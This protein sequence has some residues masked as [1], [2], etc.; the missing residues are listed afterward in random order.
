VR[1]I[2]FITEYNPFRF[3][4]GAQQRTYLLFHALQTVGHVHLFCMTEE[5]PP[6][7]RHADGYTV[8][9]WGQDPRAT[10]NASFRSRVLALFKPFI[11]NA[12][13]KKAIQA[14]QKENNFDFLVVRYL[15]PVF[16]CGLYSHRGLVLDVD[17]L[18][19]QY[20]YTMAR[21]AS[22]SLLHKFYY[23]FCALYTGWFGNRIIR[24]ATRA[25]YSNPEQVRR[26][27]GVFLP[28]IPFFREAP[29]EKYRR[30]PEKR[31]LFVGNLDYAPNR[32]GI[33]HF[34]RAIWPLVIAQVADANLEIVGALSDERQQ[35]IWTA[36]PGVTVRGFVPDLSA[37]YTDSRVVVVPVRAGAGTHIKILEAMQYHKAC[38][39]HEFAARG[40]ADFLVHGQ[41]IMLASQ[42]AD[43]AEAVIRLLTEDTLN[44]ALGE[45]AG[46]TISGR[47]TREGFERIL[48]EA[49]T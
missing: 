14:I 34:I 33:D 6:E 7:V 25:F 23:L 48:I 19:H 8:Q 3:D 1:N 44:Q 12:Y 4:Y 41:N 9:F 16:I 30:S 40:F 22:P 35:E 5:A 42:D 24:R 28:N 29:P 15:Q 32:H 38:A 26:A 10:K 36:A 11:V 39:V 21:N 47:Y 17:D 2:L 43:F 18:P 49:L 31:V 37:C 46:R 20:Y 13:Y 27:N 45:A